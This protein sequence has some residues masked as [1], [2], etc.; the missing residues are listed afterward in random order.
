M[1]REYIQ[2]L[3]LTAG[4]SFVAHGA[5]PTNILL[6]FIGGC[7]LGVYVVLSQRKP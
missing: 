6:S 4:V 5:H 2:I 1:R 7:L 3:V